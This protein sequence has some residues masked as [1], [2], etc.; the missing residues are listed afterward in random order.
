MCVCVCKAYLKDICVN[1]SVVNGTN[2]FQTIK[3]SRLDCML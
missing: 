1:P 3:N 2:Y